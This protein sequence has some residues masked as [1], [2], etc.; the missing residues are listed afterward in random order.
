VK[1]E[2]GHLDAKWGLRQLNV[3]MQPV[4]LETMARFSS[5]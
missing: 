3:P 4:P 5:T 1:V 2:N